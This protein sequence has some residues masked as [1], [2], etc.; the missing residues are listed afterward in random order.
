MKPVIALVGRPN[1][2]K[3]HAVQPADAPARRD[4]GRHARRDARPPLRRRPLGERPFIV[5]DTGG[6]EPEREDG[7]SRE[8]AHQTEQAIA[9]ADAVIFMTDA[10]AAACTPSDRVI[11][12]QLR[13]A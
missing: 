6:L 1:V 11:A 3:S 13:Q 8:M 10:R 2:G 12:E 7:I 4:R 5:V 9:E